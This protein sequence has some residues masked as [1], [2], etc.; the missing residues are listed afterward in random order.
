M[1]RGTTVTGTLAAEEQVVLSFKVAGRLRELAVDLGSHVRLGQTIARLDATD[2]YLRVKQAEATL[3]QARARLG[4]TL[5]GTDDR[6][7]PERVPLVR[8]A[9]AMYTEA[10][11]QHDRAVGLWERQLIARAEVDTA[12]TNLQV[13]EGRYQDALEEVRMRQAVLAERRSELDIA[14]QQLLD[15]ALQAPIDGAVR[16]RHASVAPGYGLADRLETL[17]SAAAE[18]N[19]PAAYTTSVSGKGREMERTLTE[20]LWA[21]LVKRSPGTGIGGQ[22]R[23][24]PLRRPFCAGTSPASCGACSGVHFLGQRRVLIPVREEDTR[25]RALHEHRYDRL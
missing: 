2:L 25:L 13:A 24:R 16:Q 1:A 11:Q 22:Y 5:E 21:F 4:L 8:Q 12:V 20:F 17:R 3:Q 6:V 7:D 15:S 19:M 18:M 10:R 23:T 14:R 9:R